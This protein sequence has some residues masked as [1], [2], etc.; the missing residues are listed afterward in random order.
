MVESEATAGGV[1]GLGETATVA[2]GARGWATS[3]GTA[4][5]PLGVSVDS[6]LTGSAR[7]LTLPVSVAILEDDVDCR[8]LSPPETLPRGEYRLRFDRGLETIVS[9]RGRARVRTNGDR[10]PN[11]DCLTLS[12]GEP[13][14]V[15]IGFRDDPPSRGTVT[16]PPTPAGLAAAVT[17]AGETPKSA[18]PE[19]SHPWFRPRSPA[20]EF[21]PDASVDEPRRPIEVRVPDTGQAVL[22]AAPL[23]YYL[24]AAVRVGYSPAI[25]AEGAGIERSLRPLPEMATDV[26]TVLRRLFDADCRLRSLPVESQPANPHPD[27]SLAGAPMAD[28]LAAAVDGT[29]EDLPPWHLAT[30]VDDEVRRGGC[31]SHLLDRLSLVYPASGS[32]LDPEAL[33]KRSLDDF[34][35]SR[36]SPR[37]DALDP[38]LGAGSTHAWLA[39]GT[40]VEAFTLLP[41]AFDRPSHPD[42]EEL[43]VAVVVND[44]DMALERDVADV[45]QSFEDLPVSVAIHERQP[46]ADLAAVFEHPYDFVHFVGHCEQGGLCCPDGSLDAGSLD[47]CRTRS[48]F[49]NACGSY[50]EGYDLVRRGATVGAVT[51]TEVFN[52]HAKTVGTAFGRLLVSGFAF[53]P[54]LGLARRQIVSG[55]DYAVVG[56]GT[57][58]LTPSYGDPAVLTVEPQE[59]EYAVTYEVQTP[60]TAGR[61]YSDP[62]GAGD[63]VYGERSCA[64]L[65]RDALSSLL[66]EWDLPVLFDG[67]LLWSPRLADALNDGQQ[68]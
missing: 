38:R 14:P 63:R 47:E 62:F 39:R 22:V 8:Q 54:A 51:L 43:A 28:R 9:F 11:D 20:V 30:Y 37:V 52:E 34:F 65:D 31:L 24:G 49:L 21:D 35:R 26:S 18:G 50:Y 45:Y 32:A 19:R 46:V 57:T 41:S 5:P 4:R 2:I 3:H 42:R 58:S 25:V 16:V 68:V 29:T 6:A 27:P 15:T 67:D 7:A 48:F 66:R 33:L 59:E 17:R 61:R 44:H 40:P 56:D 23:A 53:E 13:V 60:R 36:N 64:T 1:Y 55:R 12:F 10:V